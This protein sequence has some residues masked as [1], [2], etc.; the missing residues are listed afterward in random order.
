MI[1]RF[2]A[3]GRLRMHDVLEHTEEAVQQCGEP[4]RGVRPAHVLAV[5]ELQEK[6]RETKRGGPFS[7]SAPDRLRQSERRCDKKSVESLSEIVSAETAGNGV[8][9]TRGWWG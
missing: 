1:H 2:L 8:K 9:L 7:T 5:Q 6:R 4:R 3:V